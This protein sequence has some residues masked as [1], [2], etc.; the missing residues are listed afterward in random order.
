M[1]RE[2]RYLV[3]K[4]KDLK[5]CLSRRDRKRLAKIVGKVADYRLHRGK[6]DPTISCVVV[7]HD[8]PEYEDVWKMLEQRFDGPE[9]EDGPE[10]EGWD[11]RSGD[12]IGRNCDV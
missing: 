11:E 5:V 7:E 8:W 6:F 1:L 12:S 9:Y 3:L 10:F 4:L 2:R